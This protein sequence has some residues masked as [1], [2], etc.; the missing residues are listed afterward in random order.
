[1]VT[2]GSWEALSASFTWEGR[3]GGPLGKPTPGL[4]LQCAG[5]QQHDTIRGPMLAC[6]HGHLEHGLRAVRKASGL[7]PWGTWITRPHT[8]GGHVEERQV[9]QLNGQLS[10]VR[11]GT[12]R[13]PRGSAGPVSLGTVRN[14]KPLWCYAVTFWGDL[15]RMGTCRNDAAAPRRLKSAHL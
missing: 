2:L 15:L 7:A 6:G 13:T 14:S 12:Q 5:H 1:M 8:E 10:A 11:G 3:Q 4:E 9:L